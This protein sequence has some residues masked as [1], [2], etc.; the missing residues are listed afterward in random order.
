MQIREK[1]VK[2]GPA[3]KQRNCLPSAS[4]ALAE[5]TLLGGLIAEK[6]WF[7]KVGKIFEW[8]I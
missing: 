7:P 8:K 3:S 2:H 4:G 1:V 6:K 5:V